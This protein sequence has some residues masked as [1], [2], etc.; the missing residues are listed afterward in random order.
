MR[1]RACA[2]EGRSLARI[3]LAMVGGSELVEP[4]MVRGSSW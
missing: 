4:A 1:P 3:E 2:R